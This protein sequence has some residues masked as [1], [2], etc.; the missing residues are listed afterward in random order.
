MD[1]LHDFLIEYKEVVIEIGGHT[2]GLCKEA[3]CNYLSKARARQVAAYLQNKGVPK[4]QLVYKGYGKSKPIA[5]NRT[6]KGR[7]E[8]RRIEIK[9]LSTDG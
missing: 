2:S 4:D 1:D 3:S 7:E 8:N 6:I 9:I 5:S